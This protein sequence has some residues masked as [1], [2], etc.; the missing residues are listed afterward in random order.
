MV[1]MSNQISKEFCEHLKKAKEFGKEFEEKAK[2]LLKVC[3]LVNI[4]AE[5]AIDINKVMLVSD[6]LLDQCQKYMDHAK[7]L[8]D[9]TQ[10]ENVKH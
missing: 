3:E 10:N 6:D 2:S 8:K 4:P 9:K 7:L 5:C 1:K